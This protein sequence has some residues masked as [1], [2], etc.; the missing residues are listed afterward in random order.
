MND[1][2][3]EDDKLNFELL[4]CPFCGSKE[5]EPLFMKWEEQWRVICNLCG[6]YTT[7]GYADVSRWNTRPIT[8][9]AERELAELRERTRWIPVSERLPEDNVEVF[10]LTIQGRV[11][12]GWHNSR[13]PQWI[14]IVNYSA[15]NYANVT[16]WMPLPEPPEDA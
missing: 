15:N 13:V 5:V 8:E 16:H 7:F 12:V 14:S 10:F 6:A 9:A 3:I 4:P 11:M 2:D 1:R